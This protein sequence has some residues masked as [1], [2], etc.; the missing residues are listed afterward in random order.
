VDQIGSSGELSCDVACLDLFFCSNFPSGDMCEVDECSLT[1]PIP[2]TDDEPTVDGTIE[3]F[4]T[5]TTYYMCGRR[6]L[7]HIEIC[8]DGVDELGRT[9]ADMA[10]LEAAAV[11]AFIELAAQ[12]RRLG[13][14]QE[15]I[16]RCLAA[17]EDERLHTRWL[18]ALANHHGVRVPSPQVE[19]GAPAAT[20]LEIATHNAGEGC[21]N[22][23]WAAL[24]AHYWARSATDERLRAVFG[25]IAE[26][27]TRHGQLAWDLHQ[28]LLTQLDEP[29]RA[30]VGAAQAQAMADL[31]A[32]AGA[33]ASA[34]PAV[35]GQ[36]SAAG[37]EALATDFVRRLAA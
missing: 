4:M 14:P 37:T 29:G 9:Y 19:A 11:D 22:E 13:A 32:L 12:L 25:R 16:A 36:L 20:L 23:T 1:M 2:S 6:P 34:L 26:D 31:P 3:C 7:H 10:Y 5:E 24:C 18:T 17:A 33:Q 15:L 21:V 28:W 30:L 27:E 8:G 35:F